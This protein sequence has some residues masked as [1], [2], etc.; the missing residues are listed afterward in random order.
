MLHT[1]KTLD[2]CSSVGGWECAGEIP[3]QMSLEESD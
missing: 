1:Y 2:S 3:Q